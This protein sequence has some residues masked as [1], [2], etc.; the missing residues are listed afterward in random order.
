[1]DPTGEHAQSPAVKFVTTPS[2]KG[3]S[4]IGPRNMQVSLHVSILSFHIHGKCLTQTTT[5]APTFKT[6]ITPF[7]R[8][9]RRHHSLLQVKQNYYASTLQR[10]QTTTTT[11]TTTT[12]L[13]RPQQT[14]TPTTANDERRTTN[15]ERRTTND[16]RRTTNDER[17]TAN[18][19]RR[20]QRTATTDGGL[21]SNQQTTTQQRTTNDDNEHFEVRSLTRSLT[22]SR[23]Q[24]HCRGRIL[25]YFDIPIKGLL[26]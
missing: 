1:M 14:A 22:H 8:P 19:E 13:Q 25:K 12:T 26:M 21:S 16:E 6:T 17:R 20:R 5:V 3:V 23:T 9:R 11:T 10:P 24:P 4:D 2:S 15:D 7:T 18:N